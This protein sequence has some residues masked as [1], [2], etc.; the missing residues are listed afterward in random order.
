MAL[1][2]FASQIKDTQIEQAGKIVK[3]TIAAQNLEAAP[4][5][6]SRLAQL[7]AQKAKNS[8]LKTSVPK[9]GSPA[10]SSKKPAIDT[11]SVQ[12][13]IQSESDI[14]PAL[15]EIPLSWSDQQ[16]LCALSA[17]QIR[18]GHSAEALPY[19]MMVRKIKRMNLDIN[20]P[21]TLAVVCDQYRL[22]KIV[23]SI[24]LRSIRCVTSIL[25][26]AI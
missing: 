14:N 6:Q 20:T 2:H 18:Y 23:R 12:T 22:N 11:A 8:K 9:I 15:K 16:M 3:Q 10:K 24:C 21:L 7:E 4:A 25:L 5:K 13:A 26:M 19:L 17:M 1:N